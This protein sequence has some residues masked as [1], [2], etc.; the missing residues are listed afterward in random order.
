M[1]RKQSDSKFSASFIYVFVADVLLT[2]FGIV[3]ENRKDLIENHITTFTK[4]FRNGNN[5]LLLIHDCTYTRH[6]KVQIMNIKQNNFLGRNKC[7]D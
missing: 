7:I 5:K 3:A 4:R 2:R 6:Q 1:E